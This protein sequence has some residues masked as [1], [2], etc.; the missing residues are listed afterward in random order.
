[1][2]RIKNT[3]KRRL[4]IG[5]SQFINPNQEVEVTDEEGE[6]FLTVHGDLIDITPKKK[7][8]VIKKKSYY[9]KEEPEVNLDDI[10]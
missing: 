4:R 5:R 3:G 2:M 7:V 9:K 8:P 1:M 10:E 6:Y